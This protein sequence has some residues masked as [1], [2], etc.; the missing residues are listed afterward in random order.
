MHDR[1]ERERQ[2]DEIADEVIG[3]AAAETA[4]PARRIE[5]QQMV[6]VLVVFAD[7]KFADHAAVGKNFLH[8]EGLLIEGPLDRVLPSGAMILVVVGIMAVSIATV[9]LVVAVTVVANLSRLRAESDKQYIMSGVAK[10]WQGEALSN[11]PIFR[12]RMA[13][14]QGDRLATRES[15][16]K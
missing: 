12:I 4:V 9:T 2:I 8:S 7:P 3:Y 10:F 1:V 13:D 11:M 14:E 6:A 5:P 15:P 16:T